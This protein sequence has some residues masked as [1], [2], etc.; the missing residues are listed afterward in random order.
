MEAGP[1]HLYS[2]SRTVQRIDIRWIRKVLKKVSFDELERTSLDSHA[3]TYCGGSNTIALVLPGAQVN[4]FPFSEN[5]PAVQ[6]VPIATVLTIWECPKTGELWMLVIHEALYFGDRLKESLL[7][8]NQLRAAGVLVQD[9]PIQF[10]SKSTHSLTVPGK[11]ELPLEMHGVI[12]HLRTCKPMADKVKRYQAGLLQSVELTEDIP[13]EPYS[14]KFAETEAAARAARSVTA[15]RVPVPRSMAS[16]THSSEEEEEVNPQHPPI[17]TEHCIAVA[18]R[19][20]QSQAMVELSDDEDLASRLV[21]AI[22][23]ESDARNGDGLDERSDD[24]LCD[25]LEE[26]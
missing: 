5:L 10:D 1:K 21:A 7:C 15:P 12:S 8:P 23:I 11:L 4:V 6:D 14:E 18:S 17:L 19:L 13:W 24:P 9:A 3:N 2:E 20:S 22:N 26:D 25:T 16:S